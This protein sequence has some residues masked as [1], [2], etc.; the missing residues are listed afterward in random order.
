MWPSIHKLQMNYTVYY[1]KLDLVSLGW[2]II[3]C[4]YLS[5]FVVTGLWYA[6]TWLTP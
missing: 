4:L 6:M 3:N 1:W 2:F 5:M